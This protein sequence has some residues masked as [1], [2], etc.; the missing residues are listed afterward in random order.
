M[1][2]DKPYFILLLL[3]IGL[4]ACVELSSAGSN[5]RVL[6]EGQDSQALKRCQFLGEVSVSSEDALRNAAASMSGDTAILS[7][8]TLGD[9]SYIKGQIYRCSSVAALMPITPAIVPALSIKPIEKGIIKQ[10]PVEQTTIGGLSESE[11]QRK[12][13]KCQGLGG[14]WTGDLCVID[15]G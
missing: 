11:Q 14:R 10:T 5:I 15:P 2:I 6:P 3:S 1:N 9:M 13:Q 12:R 7:R 4:T 8:T